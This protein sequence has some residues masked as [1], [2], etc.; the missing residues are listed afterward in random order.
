MGETEARRRGDWQLRGGQEHSA[1]LVCQQGHR[2]LPWGFAL[3]L[4]AMRW[5]AG[6]G[7]APGCSHPPQGMEEGARPFCPAI[8]QLSSLTQQSCCLML[9]PL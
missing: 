6:R 4:C 1:L 5:G 2:A 9:M 8:F 7:V 3:P